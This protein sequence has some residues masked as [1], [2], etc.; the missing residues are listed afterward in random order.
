MRAEFPWVEVVVSDGSLFWCRGMHLAFETAFR[1]G[2]DH[3]VWLNDDTTLRNEALA[4]LLACWDWWRWC[5]DLAEASVTLP[6]IRRVAAIS[7][8]AV[9]DRIGL[10]GIAFLVF[11]IN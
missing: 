10:P 3:Y 8:K 7:A 2:F 5:L 1:K 11:S 9:R 4:G 6:P